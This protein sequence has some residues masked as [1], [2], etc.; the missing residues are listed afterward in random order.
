MA[1]GWAGPASG[2]GQHVAVT[3]I[4][5]EEAQ[6][7]RQKKKKPKKKPRS[8][9]PQTPPLCSVSDVSVDMRTQ[10]C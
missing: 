5:Q 8:R 4:I 3:L 6:M 9:A 7:Q 2:E 1:K 10:V